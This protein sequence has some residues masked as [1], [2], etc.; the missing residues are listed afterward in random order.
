MDIPTTLDVGKAFL[1]ASEADEK[2]GGEGLS[3]DADGFLSGAGGDEEA[4]ADEV[5]SAPAPTAL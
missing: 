1:P 5:G 3:R 4:E 2:G